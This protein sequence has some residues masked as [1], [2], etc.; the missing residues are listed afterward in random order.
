MLNFIWAFML[1]IGIV[2]GVWSG[3]LS[4]VS[5]AVL[6]SAAQAVNLAIS[7][8]GIVALWCGLMEIAD[9]AGVVK[10]LS[11]GMRPLILWLFPRLRR[12]DGEKA[13]EYI[14]LNFIMNILGTG[15][16]ATGPG[17]MAMEELDKIR[18]DKRAASDE[19]CTFLV[20]N[21]SSLQLIP[22]NIIAYRSAY[23]AVAPA[24]IIIPAL[25]TTGI[26]TM[27]AIVFCKLMCLRKGG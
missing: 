7:M 6:D 11:K 3:N 18:V 4:A 23:G 15:W 2:Y 24:A 26:S 21:I 14:T 13:A 10:L 25:I 20:L 19:M 12:E 27:A 16:S 17:L 5:N 1:L 9:K 8:S 22:V